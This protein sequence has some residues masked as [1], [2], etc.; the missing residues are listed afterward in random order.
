VTF[1]FEYSRTLDEMNLRIPKPA[2]DVKAILVDLEQNQRWAAHI[3]RLI[4]GEPAKKVVKL[5][6]VQ[7]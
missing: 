1:R 4:S 6:T 2:A 3:G 7:K 5:R